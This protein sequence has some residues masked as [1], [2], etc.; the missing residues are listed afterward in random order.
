MNKDQYNYGLEKL[1]EISNKYEISEAKAATILH[2]IQY[3]KNHYNWVNM[4]DFL[5]EYA[6][7]EKQEKIVND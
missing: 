4:H 5:L 3:F 7:G 6:W 2:D 1:K